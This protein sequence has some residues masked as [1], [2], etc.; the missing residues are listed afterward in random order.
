M[1][2]LKHFRYFKRKKTFETP[3]SST[4]HLEAQFASELGLVSSGL[5][6]FI[7]RNNYCCCDMWGSSEG[8]GQIWV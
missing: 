2:H 8:F 4:A 5:S 3:K 6:M 7:S 1:R